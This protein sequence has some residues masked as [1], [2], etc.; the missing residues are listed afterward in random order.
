MEG[1][2]LEEPQ[3]VEQARQ[4]NPAAYEALVRAYQDLV[5]R[6]AYLITG[7]AGEAEDAAQEAF[8][9]AYYAL[10]RFRHDAPFRPWVLRIVAN[11]ARNRRRGSGRRG[12]LTLR[13][14]EEAGAPATTP[15][16]E[17]AVVAAE[18]RRQVLGALHGLRD[19]DRQVVAYRYFLD[20][21]EAEMA[22]ALG[23]ARGT[24]KSRLSRALGRLRE[25]LG[26]VGGTREAGG[27][28]H[29]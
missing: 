24:V 26:D 21:S 25:R 17:A 23:C 7:D 8:I 6:A 9:K 3:L 27:A 20:L 22:S 16:A 10:P 4:G 15:S 14:A 5:F 13:V 2:P 1:A 11:E 19:E 28:A 12:H 18:Q 29:G